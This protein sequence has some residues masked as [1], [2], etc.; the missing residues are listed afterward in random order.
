VL[1]RFGSY[2]LLEEIARGGMGVVY[3]ARQVNL[4]REV[5]V[6]LLLQGALASAEDLER[7]RAE[8][9]SAGGLR[10]PS[11]VAIHEVG[12]HEGQ[13][14]F[15]MELI[16]GRDLAAKTRDGPIP[17]TQAAELLAQ[18]S[19]A[20]Q[21]AHDHGIV[22]RD[23]KP[24][25]II[26]DPEGRAH[27]T[28]FG[29]ARRSGNA[30]SLTQTGQ[31]LGTPGYMSPEQA[32]GGRNVGP[33]TDIYSL[34]ALL[35]H[36]LTSRA[37]FAGASPTTV[38]RQI[39]EREP[40]S[41]RS[42]NPSTPR[43][44]ET[45]CLKCLTKEPAR[46]YSSAG[47][48]G[49]DLRRF[50]R[51]EPIQARPAG[52][53][54][55]SWRWCR[56]RPALAGSLAG[57]VLLLI[58]I[59]ISSTLSAR[60]IGALHREV[61]LNLYAADMRLAQQAV[62]ESQFGV[63]VGLLERHR[64]RRGEPD[65]RGF[66]WRYLWDQ[67]RGDEAATLGRHSNQAQRATFS[68]DGHWAATASSEV[69]IW[70]MTQRRLL[71]SFAKEAFVWGLAFSPDSRYL[72]ADFQSLGLTC[73][74]VQEG[75]ELGELTNLVV[76][77]LSVAWEQGR[78]QKIDVIG[79]GRSF[80][81]DPRTG[82]AIERN[83]LASDIAR[84]V[85]T[86]DRQRGVA[87]S[88]KPW[89]LTLW[90]M[91]AS[92]Q[93]G[94]IKLP[95]T[96]R[97]IGLTPDGKQI[98]TGDY[99]GVVGLYNTSALSQ[100]GSF[101]AHRGMIAALAFS[102]DG[103]LLATA[104]SD[105]LIRIWDTSS[106][107]LTKT[108]HGHRSTVFTVAFSPDRRQ[109]ISGDKSGD[110][111]LWDLEATVSEAISQ[112]SSTAVLSA[113]GAVLAFSDEKARLRVCAPANPASNIL[114]S[115]AI[116]LSNCV[117]RAASANGVIL[118][119]PA[120]QLAFVRADGRLATNEL[121]KVASSSSISLSPNADYLFASIQG[122]PGVWDIRKGRQVFQGA[123]GVTASMAADNVHLALGFPNG[124]VQVLD[125][126]DGRTLARFSAHAGFCYAC[127]FSR[128]GRRLATAGFDGL[129][130]LSDAGTGKLI[131][132]FRSSA[133]AYWTVALS[134][135]GRR[136]AAGTGVSTVVLWDVTSGQEV[137]SLSLGE[138]LRPVEGQLRFTPH[139]DALVIADATSW[140]IWRAP[141]Q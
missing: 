51:D 70:D 141:F 65:L 14:Y 21:H 68:P 125:L 57:V 17:A 20:I 119:L 67:C 5:A 1:R 79:S 39:E 47:A 34:G 41:P 82:T 89:R 124:V 37:P 24:S 111:K 130:K 40:I 135:D 116:P 49:E 108:L 78:A 139:G 84:L 62:A 74:D 114:D 61:S 30:L 38:L 115:T 93:L 140:K 126:R 28:D 112:G 64:P 90:D 7:F 63:A 107:T 32:A 54:E 129:V 77:P 138:P 81:W 36:L 43:D 75:R 23:L 19:D 27:V 80:S 18:V 76:T 50:L 72:T 128:D 6:K 69:N 96:I 4:D 55:R 42:L 26:V 113:D 101:N 95:G 104:G 134:P 58:A 29:L 94:E 60:R 46:R 85:L 118:A 13:H 73:Y 59:T 16:L 35:Y 127:D 33:A 98:A 83:G 25:N 53:L 10:H 71:R 11:I 105:Q 22:H 15:S 44:L 131:A 3:R 56:R 110:I 123:Q 99:S 2:E 12:E 133:D 109:L 52:P 91:N 45:I 106:W 132:T 87:L 9:T 86:P 8:A 48:L 117:P 121:P 137:G 122:E 102:A 100:T 66:E 97:S 103:H 136:I 88:T 120:G 92:Q 31:A